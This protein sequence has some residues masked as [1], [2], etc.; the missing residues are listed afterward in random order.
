MDDEAA[1]SIDGGYPTEAGSTRE[2]DDGYP[3]EASGMR[4][5]SFIS[6]IFFSKIDKKIC[7]EI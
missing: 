1:D 7:F 5:R 4:K 3:N 6:S 2:G